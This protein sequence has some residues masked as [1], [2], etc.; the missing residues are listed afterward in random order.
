M[1]CSQI[2]KYGQRCSRK[3]DNLYCWQH[4]KEKK[5]DI[6][7]TNLKLF[8]NE[9]FKSF[10][11]P[12]TQ[13]VYN[14]IDF[15]FSEI[16][17]V[18]N[19]FDIENLTNF[20]N[21]TYKGNLKKMAS[22]DLESDNTID[23]LVQDLINK[24]ISVIQEYIQNNKLKSFTFK[25]FNYAIYKSSELYSIL[26]FGLIPNK[27]LKLSSSDLVILPISYVLKELQNQKVGI[28]DDGLYF[29]RQYI[30]ANFLNLSQSDKA[31]C[32]FSDNIIQ[33]FYQ[34]FKLIKNKLITQ[35]KLDYKTTAD[36]VLC[37]DIF[38]ECQEER[39]KIYDE[40]LNSMI[41]EDVVEN[42]LDEYIY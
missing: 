22:K 32:H 29:I 40:L 42:I 35:N 37:Y 36:I 15:L 14:T 26:G 3:T 7:L 5:E 23:L 27:Y 1:Q 34:W 31:E 8:M 21:N 33:F 13:E 28:N 4:Q 39:R 16:W 12:I 9:R 20:I 18:Y 41:T 6:R 30:V 24:L 10:K 2:L 17:R 38:H 19:S 25:D 11:I